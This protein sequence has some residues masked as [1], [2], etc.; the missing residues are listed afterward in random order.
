[1]SSLIQVDQSGIHSSFSNKIGQNYGVD[2]RASTNILLVGA[3]MSRQYLRILLEL[4][5]GARSSSMIGTIVRTLLQCCT[6]ECIAV[7]SV[8]TVRYPRLAQGTLK[9]LTPMEST[10][11]EKDEWA[12]MLSPKRV[13]HQQFGRASA[14][15]FP[16][17][18]FK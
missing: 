11:W 14:G 13:L 10:P 18:L 5:A 9:R 16:N 1:M 2:L 6:E 7:Q 12:R 8:H 17:F 15:M 4:F 3:A